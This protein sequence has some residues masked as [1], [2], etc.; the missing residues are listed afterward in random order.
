[1]T[2]L[3]D[4]VSGV[5]QVPKPQLPVEPAIEGGIDFGACELK[6]DRHYIS[7]PTWRPK[8]YFRRIGRLL[9]LASRIRRSQNIASCPISGQPSLVVES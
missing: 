2:F 3:P 5:Y 8:T 4:L 1:M 9:L 7:H 6:L